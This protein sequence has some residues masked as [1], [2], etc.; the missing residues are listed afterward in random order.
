MKLSIIIPVYRVEATLDRC[1]AS[2]TAQME[3]DW[4]VILVDD[5]SPDQCPQL[6]DEWAR[7]DGRVRVIHK[8]N[9]GLSDARNAGLDAAR[10]DLIAFADSDDEV[11][12]GTY[13]EA[14][15]ALDDATDIVEFPVSR[16]H[17]SPRQSLLTFD[18]AVYDDM[19]GYWLSGH[20]YEHTY[21]WNKVYRRELFADARFP[22]GRVFE[23]VW[24]LP[25]LLARTRRV[26]TIGRG[27]YLYHDNPQGITATAQGRQLLDL[28]EAHLQ[29]LPRWADDRYYMHVLNIQLDVCRLTGQPPQLPTRRVSPTVP[30]LTMS[31]RLKA[32][33]LRTMGLTTLVRLHLSTH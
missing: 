21:A 12:P 5:G 3:A 13:R 6:C 23:D 2:V 33:V 19:A 22:V 4:E 24:T 1:L 8:A 20:A 7:R 15:G 26:R 32:L 31:Q 18:D 29:V 10:G 28:L 25:L 17:G 16:W 27:L 14:V 9:G 30:G 11:A